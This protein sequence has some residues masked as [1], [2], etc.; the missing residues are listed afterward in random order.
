[1]F[2]SVNRMAGIGLTLSGAGSFDDWLGSYED[3]HSPGSAIA[4]QLHLVNLSCLDSA[5]GE[6]MVDPT[7]TREQAFWIND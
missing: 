4:V 5:R 2:F 7:L 6:W 3:H 1:M